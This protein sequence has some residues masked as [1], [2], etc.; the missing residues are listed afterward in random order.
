ML[1]EVITEFAVVG[2]CFA[3]GRV[4]RVGDM[5]VAQPLVGL[6]VLSEALVQPGE[7]RHEFREPGAQATGVRGVAGLAQEGCQGFSYNFV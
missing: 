7:A 6:S 5:E 3:G 4:R 1:Y 2:L